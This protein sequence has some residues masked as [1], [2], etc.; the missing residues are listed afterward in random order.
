MLLIVMRGVV[1]TFSLRSIT[2]RLGTRLIETPMDVPP[3]Q[4][5]YARRVA[6]AITR[7][8]ARTPTNSNCYPQGLTAWWLLH[9]KRIPTTFYYG[10]AFDEDGTAL[11][12][13]VWVR[14]GPLIITGGGSHRRRF[15]PLV[16]YADG[17][18]L[19]S[20]GGSDPS[21]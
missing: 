19:N 13:H 15:A 5:R 20:A 11:Q 17:Q 18:L 1:R 3:E 9:R 21:E 10:A 12:A 7:V 16:W 6:W 8:S 14:C 2:A 4:L